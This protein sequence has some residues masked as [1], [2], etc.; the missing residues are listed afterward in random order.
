V[1]PILVV[2]RG[3]TRLEPKDGKLVVTAMWSET[4]GVRT[5]QIPDS[6]EQDR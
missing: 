5:T 2:Q 4:N 1:T 6:K 3:F